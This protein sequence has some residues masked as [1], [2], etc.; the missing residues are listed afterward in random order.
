MVTT[1]RENVLASSGGGRYLT[2]LWSL[3][4]RISMLKMALRPSSRDSNRQV[5]NER[6]IPQ[7]R[8]LM[9]TSSS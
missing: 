6:G 4:P 1:P 8:N 5:S 2:R 7:T 9:V 3:L